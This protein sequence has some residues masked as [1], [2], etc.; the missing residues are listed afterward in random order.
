MV[1]LLRSGKLYVKNIPILG[2]T[3]QYDIVDS[4]ITINQYAIHTPR[5]R[6]GFQS[7]R[8]NKY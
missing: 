5:L 6:V 7:N 1:F 2:I 8:L 3:Y 4:G